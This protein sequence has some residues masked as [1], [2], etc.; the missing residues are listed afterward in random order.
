M[1]DEIKVPEGSDGQKQYWPGDKQLQPGETT[2][3]EKDKGNREHET[4]TIPVVQ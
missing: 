4:T 2:C 3:P 1:S